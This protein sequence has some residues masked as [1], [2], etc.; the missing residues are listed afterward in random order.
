MDPRISE[1]AQRVPE[2]ARKYRHWAVMGAVTAGAL[3][4]ATA[5]RLDSLGRAREQEERRA[6]VAQ[7][8]ETAR[9]WLAAFQNPTSAETLAWR[10][11]EAQMASLSEAN[12]DRLAAARLV[13]ERAQA[14]GI[15]TVRLRFLSADSLE[16]ALPTPPYGPPVT[17][18]DWVLLVEL[19][20][21]L[22]AVAQFLDNLP[23]GLGVWKLEMAKG[24]AGIRTSLQLLRYLVPPEAEARG[25][26]S[27][28]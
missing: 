10:S 12:P 5:I 19:E 16:E 4:V 6:I 21:G 7:Q 14:A 15:R 25:G 17:L 11:S 23:T 24:Q 18:A 20:G 8:I 27:S 2:L 13:A 1:I 22:A 3:V 28:P 26:G 9:S